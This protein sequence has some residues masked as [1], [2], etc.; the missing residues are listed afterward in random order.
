MRSEV[1]NMVRPPVA[2]GCG[3]A[4]LAAA[5]VVLAFVFFVVFLNGGSASSTVTLAAADS[6]APGTVTYNGDHRFYIV[7]LKEGQFII[8]ADMDAANE[9]ST[10]RKCRVQPLKPDDPK[11]LPM[12]NQYGP[13]M[14]PQ[15]QSTTFLFREACNGAVYDITGV[16]LD[17]TGPNLARYA[18]EID[19]GGKLVVDLRSKHCS[20]R[21]STNFFAPTACVS[22]G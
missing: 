14:S 10:T 19:P 9:A 18:S 21:G 1:R 12:L 20:L 4:V 22:E 15:A 6:Y 11:L 17:G 2:L 5:G 16:R 7:R 13:K 3:T 8:L